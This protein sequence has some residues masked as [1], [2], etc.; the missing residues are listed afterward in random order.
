MIFGHSF[1]FISAAVGADASRH[2]ELRLA[3]VLAGFVPVEVAGHWGMPER[4]FKVSHL[5]DPDDL[6]ALEALGT[7]FNQEAVFHRVRDVNSL[8]FLKTGER[9]FGVGW[10]SGAFADQ[11]TAVGP[12]KVQFKVGA[13]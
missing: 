1:S 5:G 12:F 9:T 2:E 6:E 4:S 13:Q 7:R 3:L 10:E 8:V 11:F